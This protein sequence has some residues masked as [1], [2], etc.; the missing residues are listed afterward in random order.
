[1][2]VLKY[3]DASGNWVEVDTLVNGEFRCVTVE[4]LDVSTGTIGY[5]LSPWVG[6]G[7]NF[8]LV[9]TCDLASSATSGDWFNHVVYQFDG[10]FSGLRAFN[11]DNAN[12][13]VTLGNAFPAETQFD[14]EYNQETR[15]LSCTSDE[16]G[17]NIANGCRAFNAILFYCG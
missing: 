13:G 11:K 9:F 16:Y 17:E 4:P 2:S 14:I 1:M 3:K 6:A 7:A 15:V 5:D 8:M 10:V 12:A